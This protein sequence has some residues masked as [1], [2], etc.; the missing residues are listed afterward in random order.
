MSA[1]TRAAVSLL[2]TQPHGPDPVK[3]ASAALSIPVLWV[4]ELIHKEVKRLAQRQAEP[5]NYRHGGAI[6]CKERGVVIGALLTPRCYPSL[7]P[8]KPQDAPPLFQQSQTPWSLWYVPWFFLDP[9]YNTSLSC[10][11]E[12][13]PLRN[14]GVRGAGTD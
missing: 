12:P 4:R 10:L 8:L 13:S 3:W 7:S 14:S 9:C 11:T 6:Y 1:V 5:M 2:L